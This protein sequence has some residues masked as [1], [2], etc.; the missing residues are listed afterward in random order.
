MRWGPDVHTSRSPVRRTTL[1]AGRRQRGAA[2]VIGLLLLVVITL[3][4]IGGMNS[5]SVELVLAGN[6]QRQALAFQASEVG[7][8]NTL[9]F[10]LA[11]GIDFQP[12]QASETVTNQ[13]STMGKYDYT[14][15]SDLKGAPQPALWGNTWNAFS[16][17]HFQIESMG[18]AARGTKTTHSQGTA[19]MSPYDAAVTYDEKANPNN[20]SNGGSGGAGAGSVLQ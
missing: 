1:H 19:R 7:I 5:A 16:T 6:T 10:V 9:A 8:E 18:T 17:Y 2:L 15:R 4:A 20:P 3:L 13:P 11:P 12:G 14:L